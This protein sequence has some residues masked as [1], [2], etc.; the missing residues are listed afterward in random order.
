MKK[1]ALTFLLIVAISERHLQAEH[2]AAEM[3]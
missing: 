2:D 1:Q 3:E